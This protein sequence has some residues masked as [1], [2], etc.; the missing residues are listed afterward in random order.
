VVVSF[1]STE[2]FSA[3]ALQALA[4]FLKRFKEEDR[5]GLGRPG[6]RRRDVLLLMRVRK[7]LSLAAVIGLGLATLTVAAETRDVVGAT[8]ISGRYSFGSEDF[9]N[10]GADRL[11]GMGTRV[12]KVWLSFNPKAQYPWNSAWGRRPTPCS[13]RRRSPTSA[14]SSPSPSPP[15]C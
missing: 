10:E 2:D 4:D 12:I 6:D 11:L 3:Q 15:S 5:P 13:P 1:A 9:L 8:H 14:S 7:A